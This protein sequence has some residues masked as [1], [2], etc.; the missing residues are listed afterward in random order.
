MAMEVE[1]RVAS[2]GGAWTAVSDVV[3]F[4]FRKEINNLY[5]AEVTVV[6]PP[7]AVEAL[8]LR[9]NELRI[10]STLGNETGL[11]LHFN[12][13]TLTS[14]GLMDDLSGNSNEGTIL[15]TV[16]AV[17]RWDRSRDFSADKITVV[18]N[19]DIDY[20]ANMSVFAWVNADTFAQ[21]SIVMKGDT[22]DFEYEL[23]MENTSGQLLGVIFTSA[24]G[25]HAATTSGL[26][27]LSTATW[28]HVGFTWDEGNIFTLYL[29]GEIVGTDTVFSGSPAGGARASTLAI[30]SRNNDTLQWDGRI[31]EVYKVNRTLSQNEVRDLMRRTER[32]RGKIRDMT[33]DPLTKI[34]NV[35]ALGTAVVLHD[36]SWLGRRE[37]P[38]V[39]AEVSADE[40]AH[41]LNGEPRAGLEVLY[42]METL[43]GDAPA[44]MEDLS[45]SGNDGDITGTSSVVGKWG[46]GRSNIAES[47]EIV[48][49]GY[50]HDGSTTVGFAHGGFFQVGNAFATRTVQ[51]CI[52]LDAGSAN[53]Q[54]TIRLTGPA[55]GLPTT[56]AVRFN[57]SVE[58]FQELSQAFTFTSGQIYHIW[59]EWDGSAVSLYVDGQQLG[60][61]LTATGTLV[62]GPADMHVGHRASAADTETFNG[63]YDQIM[64]YGVALGADRIRVVAGRN[65]LP[66]HNGT[67]DSFTAI[68]F[69]S[70]E[71]KRGV[72]IET[73]ARSVGAEVFVDQNASDENRFN[74]VDRIGSASAT[75]I[76][77]FGETA[78]LA[79]RKVDSESI[80]NDI[81]VLGYGDGINQ[82]KSRNFHATTIRSTVAIRQ[83][84]SASTLDIADASSYPTSGIIQ[85]GRERERYTGK[86]GNQLTGISG[87]NRA[88][89]ADGYESIA[90]YAHEVGIEV[91]LHADTTT[92]PDS[93][94]TPEV[95]QTGSS[96]KDNG[97]RQAPYPAPELIDQ[98][99]ADRLAQRFLAKY[100]DERESVV[101]HIY[102][103]ALLADLGDD[104]TVQDIA[105]A[106]YENSPYRIAAMEF[107]W[108]TTRWEL[109]L[110]NYRDTIDRRM[111]ELGEK[112]RIANEFGQGA[113]NFYPLYVQEN[114]KGGSRHALMD[115]TIPP[116]ALAVNSVKIANL[117]LRP[118]EKYTS[119]LNIIPTVTLNHL[120]GSN[121]A[122]VTVALGPGWTQILTTNLQGASPSSGY[123]QVRIAT[124]V[125]YP[126]TGGTTQLDVRVL[127]KNGVATKNTYP[128][129]AGYSFFDDADPSGM[130]FIIAEDL[131]QNDFFA[132]EMRTAGATVAPTANN[133]EIQRV[134]Q[135]S[136]GPDIVDE[137]YTSPSVSIFI[138]GVDKTSV[139]KPA[140]PFTTDTS[141]IDLTGAVDWTQGIHT[142]EFREGTTDK[143]GRIHASGFVTTFLKSL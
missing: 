40:L 34:F 114:V 107:K 3:A 123:F 44:K 36:R 129:S 81:T 104:V 15:G 30:G 51:T 63:M 27:N 136:H 87:A 53:A 88:Y 21:R 122:P 132:L 112:M 20:A 70:E 8:L 99:A 82:L 121:N 89:T 1:A 28:H 46:L 111:A 60:S 103:E 24:G 72:T 115:V 49:T 43:T 85:A 42:D 56:I 101:L 6:N 48:A 78:V 130:S 16:D 54:G 134:A 86:T 64:S 126:W 7:T 73:L 50:N 65:I 139:V 92:T 59:A 26:T 71:E 11:V 120:F 95:P 4:T 66:G 47:D 52:G 77:K 23:R 91:F 55:G 75:D 69:R 102:E 31:D 96:I 57:T 29:D 142:V 117:R 19:A 5:R 138:D 105:G 98:N 68:G 135:H 37:F 140:G 108:P 25:S 124:E 62:N 100:K 22:G 80:Y 97:W 106:A 116:E 2:P 133:M 76:F 110:A 32:Y 18:G 109:E 67:I 90:A 127:L 84:A 61:S 113:T 17:G 118:F 33:V 125:P 143:L 12:M 14:A 45:G 131:V 9:D 39:P 41:S 94:Y 93:Y 137:A 74:F 119:G 79:S 128:D 35:S 10:R 13:L 141:N 58:G 83:S 38:I